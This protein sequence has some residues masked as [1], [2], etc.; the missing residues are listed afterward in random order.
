MKVVCKLCC[1][2]TELY[3]WKGTIS[4][5]KNNVEILDANLV[6]LVR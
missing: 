2:F 5:T 1:T 3:E 4:F 6:R